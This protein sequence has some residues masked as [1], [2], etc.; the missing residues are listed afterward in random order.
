MSTDIATIEPRTGALVAHGGEWQALREQAQTLIKSGFLPTAV[1]TP[2]QCLAIFLTGRELGIGPMQAI[3]SIHII[4]GKPTLSAGL[5]LALAYQRVPGFKAEVTG[6]AAAA[7]GDFSRPGQKVYRSE[8]TMEDAKRAGLTGKQ[9]WAKYPAQMLRA[10]VVADGVRMVAPEVAMGLYT[11]D[12]LGAIETID[13]VTV[14]PEPQPAEVVQ[15]VEAAPVASPN[16]GIREPQMAAARN[17]FRAACIERFGSDEVGTA[18][19]NAWLQLE[20]VQD[21]K[22]L[23]IPALRDLTVKVRA[24][25]QEVAA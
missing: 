6:D 9:N 5:L 7:V 15:P 11:P 21:V 3:R 10:R 25:A 22:S 23:S 12:E 19:A 1:K 14:E 16:G 4:E 17:M 2:E 20:G 18:K 8:F 24:E 13:A